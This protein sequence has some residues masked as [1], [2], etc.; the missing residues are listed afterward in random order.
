MPL[1]VTCHVASDGTK[2]ESSG[3]RHHPAVV[4]SLPGDPNQVRIAVMT[5]HISFIVHEQLNPGHGTNPLFG[6]LVQGSYRI[7]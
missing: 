7:M 2:L 4:S 3:A 1:H 5:Q 6:N